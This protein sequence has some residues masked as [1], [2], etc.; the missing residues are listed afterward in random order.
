PLVLLAIQRSLSAHEVICV[1]NCADALALLAR[2]ER[3]DVIL[4]DL[5]MPG[6]TGI[7]FFEE[8]AR[9]SRDQAET[10]V[11]VTGGA[12]T[13]TSE[14]F[15]QATTNPCIEKPFTSGSLQ[16]LVTRRLERHPH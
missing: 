8:L 11:F 16:A 5:A 9:R 13:A 10:V 7:A 2:G 4:T 15:L 14:D 6:M 1:D 3:F 12:L